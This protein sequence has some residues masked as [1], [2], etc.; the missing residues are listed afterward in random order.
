MNADHYGG[1]EVALAAATVRTLRFAKR[2]QD[3]EETSNFLIFR[4]GL[5]VNTMETIMY[6]QYLVED[7]CFLR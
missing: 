3:F 7:R 2:P 6:C 4:D 5:L 1:T